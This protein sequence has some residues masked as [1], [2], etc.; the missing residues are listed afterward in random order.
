MGLSLFNES[1]MGPILRHFSQDK[2]GR[3]SK[4]A[5]NSGFFHI[6]AKKP[7]KSGFFRAQKQSGRVGFVPRSPIYTNSDSF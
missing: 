4:N 3:P 7:S 6:Y 5:I 1:T 2:G